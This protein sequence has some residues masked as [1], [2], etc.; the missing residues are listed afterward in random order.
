MESEVRNVPRIRVSITLP[1]ECLEWMDQKIGSRI[2]ANRSH[3]I[4][5]IIL[6]VK[7]KG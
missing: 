1:K 7:K 4:E 5:V 6:E 3:A 2:Y